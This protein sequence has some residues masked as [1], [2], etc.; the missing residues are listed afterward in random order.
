MAKKQGRMNEMV[1]DDD[2]ALIGDG[3]DE[4]A[5]GSDEELEPEPE[6]EIQEQDHV[7]VVPQQKPRVTNKVF[8][9]TLMHGATYTFRNMKFNNM[10]PK[11]VPMQYYDMFSTNG[12]FTCTMTPPRH[13][14]PIT[15]SHTRR[16]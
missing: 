3:V 2:L 6:S 11:E 7:N 9:A 4:D 1:S 12:W 15:R 16:R 13:A 8:Y 14:V 5:F 10:E